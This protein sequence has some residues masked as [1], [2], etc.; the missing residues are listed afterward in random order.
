MPGL[1][2]QKRYI[3]KDPDNIVKKLINYHDRLTAKDA[4][5]LITQ[6]AV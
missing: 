4:Y 5:N 1:I 2:N 3:I 6:T